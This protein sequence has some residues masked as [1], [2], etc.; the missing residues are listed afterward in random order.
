MNNNKK[1][2]LKALKAEL[3]NLKSS[4]SSK[5]AA[6]KAP[7]ESHKS[8][9][10][11]DIKNSY[12]QNLHMR[13]S[14]YYLWLISW[15][16]YF[17]N[18]IPYLSRIVGFLSLIYGRTTWW[19]ILMKVRRLFVVFN[20]IIGMYVVY[21]TTGFGLDN[22][23]A[24][25]AAIGEKY[26][27]IFF[28]FN[29]IAFNW[30][31]DLFDYKIIPGGNKPPTPPTNPFIDRFKNSSVLNI[32]PSKP[33]ITSEDPITYSLR[34]LYKDAKIEPSYSSWYTWVYYTSLCL[35]V[36]VTVGACY[37]GYKFITEP[38]YFGELLF[39]NQKDIKGKAVDPGVDI[40]SDGSLTPLL[41][42]LNH[43]INKENNL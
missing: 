39:N 20:A 40:G 11:H 7:I 37:L 5:G 36:A 25:F 2:T 12:I 35:G 29:K 16:I 43:I 10:A 28:N 18:K 13:S 3:D 27:D 6:T 1:L 21:K 38:G 8:S 26:V 15:V 19:K 9:V 14:M 17:A 42:N 41:F 4:K 34:N 32:L 24:N 30:L 33:D 31:L 23:W 22:F